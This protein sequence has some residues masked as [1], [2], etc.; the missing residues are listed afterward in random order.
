M[1]ISYNG[2]IPGVGV[3]LINHSK[4][5][6]NTKIQWSVKGTRH[7][8]WLEQ[9]IDVWGTSDHAGLAFD[10]IALRDIEKDE[11]IFIDYSDEWQQAWDQ[12]VQKWNPPPGSHQYQPASILNEMHDAVIRTVSEGSYNPE[13]DKILYCREIYREYAGAHEE[14][15][16][17]FQTCRALHRYVGPD[18]EYRYIVETFS[19]IEGE[20]FC[21]ERGHFI[22]F[23]LP[24]DGFNFRDAL[25]ALDHSQRWA[26]RHD[27]RI[28]D[29][30]MPEAWKNLP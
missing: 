8:E 5:K 27:L 26:F 2:D 7:P 18:G 1:L 24:R 14:S 21:F 3:G 12:H 19:E 30:L 15:P 10:L 4:E 23:D 6:V 28:P 13:T 9:S 29:E 17:D 16:Y 20:W 25:Y 11:E 22:I